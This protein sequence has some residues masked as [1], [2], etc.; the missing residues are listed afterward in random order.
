MLNFT[1]LGG[2]SCAAVFCAYQRGG[3]EIFRRK[4][5]PNVVIFFPILEHRAMFIEK[6]P[7]LVPFPAAWVN[8]AEKAVRF[9]SET[10][11]NGTYDFL[12]ELKTLNSS[13]TEYIEKITLDRYC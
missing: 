9:A 5:G 6:V 8:G 4:G 11:E 10:L 12:K 1:S 7:G 2:R 13:L 3:L